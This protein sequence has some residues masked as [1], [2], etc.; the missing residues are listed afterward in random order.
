M[1]I[2]IEEMYEL[3][4]KYSKEILELEMK[5]AVVDDLIAFA[6]AKE[7]CKSDEE[8]VEEIEEVETAEETAVA[9]NF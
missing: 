4:N 1:Y 5:K 6:E 3:K 8:E 2:T 7:P 9:T